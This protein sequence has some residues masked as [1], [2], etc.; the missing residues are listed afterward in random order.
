MTSLVGSKNTAYNNE[1]QLLYVKSVASISERARTKR[2]DLQ[3]GKEEDPPYFKLVHTGVSG[4]GIKTSDRANTLRVVSDNGEVLGSLKLAYLFASKILPEGSSLPIE[5]KVFIDGVDGNNPDLILR[6]KGKHT[7]RLTVEDYHTLKITA[8]SGVKSH[9]DVA[10]V[11]F[12]YTSVE[13]TGAIRFNTTT[14]KHQGFDGT[15]WHDLY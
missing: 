2:I 3:T 14:R 6:A 11:I 8:E 13:K 5:G 7:V 1:K 15:Q 4:A 9:I 10:S 12:G